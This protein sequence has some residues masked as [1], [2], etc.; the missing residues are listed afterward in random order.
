MNRKALG[1]GL[2]ALLSSDSTI[3]LGPEPTEV[4]LDSIVPGPMQPRTHFDEGG[5]EGLADSIRTHGI[6]QPLLV[7]RQGNRYELIAGERRWRA[8]RLAGL[9]KVP[10]VVKDV[11]DKDLLEIALIENIQRE[12]LNPIEEAQAYQRLIE[13]VGLTQEALAARVG[14]DRSYITNYLRLLRLPEDLQQ[15][16][17][18]GRLS[19]GHARTIL[20]LSHVDLQRRVARQVID[21]ALSVRATEHLVRKAVDGSPAKTAVAV[22]P[23]IRA[24]ETKLRRA[25]G[26]QVRIV[27]LR[28]EGQ[29]K[30]EISFFSNQ[31]LDRIYN[32]LL[33]ATQV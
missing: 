16:V 25:L 4:E 14:R 5:L 17:V 21:G 19:T 31:D 6:V 24:A 8:A 22:D 3:D 12:N 30:V 29:G 13:N 10:V 9:A 1:R 15:L 2:G 33:S 20:G 32:L 23:N 11:P 28:G 27:Q 18:E 26:T 7:R